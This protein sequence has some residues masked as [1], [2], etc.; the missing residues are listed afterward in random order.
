MLIWFV[1][2]I[3]LSFLSNEKFKFFFKFILIS[4]YINGNLLY[5]YVYCLLNSKNLLI[6]VYLKFICFMVIFLIFVEKLRMFF[7]KF[8]RSDMLV[9]FIRFRSFGMVFFIVWEN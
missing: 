5:N 3:D 9:F 7:K 2:S 1:Y 8:F 6:L 4:I